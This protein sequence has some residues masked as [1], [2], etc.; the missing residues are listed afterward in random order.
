MNIDRLTDDV[1]AVSQ[2]YAV[3]YGIEPDATWYLL[4]SR[5]KSVS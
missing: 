1:E 2:I 5:K 3:R 4:N